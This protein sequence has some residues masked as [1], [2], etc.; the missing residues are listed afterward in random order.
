MAIIL[1]KQLTYTFDTETTSQSLEIGASARDA[2]IAQMVA[3]GKTN[4][5]WTGD[6]FNNRRGFIDQA[7]AEEFLA[8]V[9]AWNPSRTIVSSSI[10][11]I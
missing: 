8:A 3:D 6:A 9:P 1:T 5:I 7:A 11:D 4:G 2:F 10:T